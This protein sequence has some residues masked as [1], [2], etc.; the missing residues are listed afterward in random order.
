MHPPQ[1]SLLS[2]Q[3][4]A[5]GQSG[6]AREREVQTKVCP[7]F[8]RIISET[9]KNEPLSNKHLTGFVQM[10]GAGCSVANFKKHLHKCIPD[11]D[12]QAEFE[13]EFL[14]S[15]QTG[16]TGIGLASVFKPDES[17]L[18]EVKEFLLA[19]FN[20]KSPK[21]A[22][23]LCS[24]FLSLKIPQLTPGIFSPWLHYINPQLF[25]IFNN[26]H[27]TFRNWLGVSGDY[28]QFIMEFNELAQMLNEE[29][30]GMIDWYAHNYGKESHMVNLVG[31]RLFKVSHSIF[32]HYPEFK[33][34]KLKDQLEQNKWISMGLGTKDGQDELFMNRAAVGDYV[35][36]CYGGK[37]LYCIAEI[38]SDPKDFLEA[39]K[40]RNVKDLWKFREIKPLFFAVDN[41]T[42]SL[43]DEHAKYMPQGNSTIGEVP[44]DKIQHLN[45]IL[46]KP[47]FNVEFLTDGTPTPPSSK[48]SPCNTILFGPPGTGK[49]YLSSLL[50]LQIMGIPLEELDRI[51]LKTRFSELQSARRIFFSTFHQNMAYEDFIEGIKPVVPEEDDGFLR[52][53]VQDGL[54]MKACVEATFNY[55]QR[56]ALIMTDKE[57]DNQP[58]PDIVISYEDKRKLVKDYWAG[59]EYHLPERDLSEP[60]VFIIDE[61]NRGNVAQIF[62][63]LIT[64]LEDDKRMGRPEM[65]FA[66]LPYSKQSFAIPPN[67]FIVGTMNT[68]DR[69]VEA[70]DTALRRR[71]SFMEMSPEPQLLRTAGKAP[72]GRIAD[73]DLADLLSI[74]NRRIEK[75]LDR[76][77]LVG[78]SFFLPLASMSELKDAFR[79][80]II[81]LLQEYFY[82]DIGKIG[83]VLGEGFMDMSDAVSSADIFATFNDYDIGALMERKVYRIRDAESMTD[84]QFILAI[85]T[86]MQSGKA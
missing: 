74:I 44:A 36:I 30:L 41:S 46:F 55:I 54:F 16:Y 69:S 39:D 29:D 82:G 42:N 31:K 68:A 6:L 58:N 70:L 62:G 56:N 11:P 15:G 1:L 61:I 57:H 28:P 10:F 8:R 5:F 20:V 71:F 35:Y 67:L 63:E 83:L 59:K 72:G 51:A 19:A 24:D 43:K 79:S 26:S 22:T 17:Q 48:A 38:T 12:L 80:K 53:E 13:R 14:Q 60:Y 75:L 77:H 27:A 76:D 85:N 65:L 3:Y 49:T 23:K 25:P 34:A 2:Q 84:E 7:L 50:A 18:I 9:I 45:E 64:L 4:A 33:R 78:H 52:Y 86:L 40:L 37:T 73:I 21:E 47:K 32:V 66:E 81:P